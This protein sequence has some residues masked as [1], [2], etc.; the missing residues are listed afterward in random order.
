MTIRIAY[1]INHIDVAFHVQLLILSEFNEEMHTTNGLK[2]ISFPHVIDNDLVSTRSD[3]WHINISKAALTSSGLHHA[4]GRTYTFGA[5]NIVSH[6]RAI[7][8][9][10]K[11]WFVRYES[12]QSTHCPSSCTKESS[13]VY[14]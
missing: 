12:I 7:S 3:E 13:G 6:I 11:Y 5:T 2:D 4:N 8:Y 14:S 1:I 10:F 9:G